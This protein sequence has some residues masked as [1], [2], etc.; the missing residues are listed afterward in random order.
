MDEYERFKR[1]SWRNRALLWWEEGK[2]AVSEWWYHLR[3]PDVVD[4]RPVPEERNDG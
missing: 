1:A 4:P 2:L 3:N